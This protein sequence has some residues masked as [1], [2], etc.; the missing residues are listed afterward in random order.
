MNAILIPAV[1][2]V[3]VRL[4]GGSGLEIAIAGKSCSYIELPPAR[5]NTRQRFAGDR[6]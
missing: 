5:L 4:A 1:P 2:P 3:A 6:T